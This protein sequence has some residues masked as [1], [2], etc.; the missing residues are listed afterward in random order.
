MTYQLQPIAHIHTPF[1]DKFG[2]PRQPGLVESIKGQVI[3]QAPFD[4][5]LMVEGLT[6]FSHIWLNFVF[7]A[8]VDKGWRKRVRPPRL[9]GNEKKGVFATRSPFRPNHLGLSVVRLNHI[10][11]SNGVSLH[12][13]GVDLM[14]GTP[15]VDIKPYLPYVDG[16]AGATGGFASKAPENKMPI[17]FLTEALQ[18]IE[19]SHHPDLKPLIIDLLALDPRP[20]Y[21][22]GEAG[23][24]YHMR[25]YDYDVSWQVED[26]QVCVVA[27]D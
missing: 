27:I 23:R 20:A 9:G 1:K 19:Q 3:M 8:V 17:R 18:V 21:H 11:I 15:I 10:D 26:G 14:H 25:L 7:D 6:E 13:Q 22:Q 12:V 4:D 5:P 24:L 16:V 2:I